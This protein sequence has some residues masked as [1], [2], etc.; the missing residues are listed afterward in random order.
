MEVPPRLTEPLVLC[1]FISGLFFQCCGFVGRHDFGGVILFI[2]IIK[3]LT[4]QFLHLN[5]FFL[6]LFVSSCD[7]IGSKSIPSLVNG[8]G[9]GVCLCALEL[10]RDLTQGLFFGSNWRLTT[11][12]KVRTFKSRKVCIHSPQCCPIQSETWQFALYT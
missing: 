4:E 6:C 9:I 1:N 10:S 7:L 2:I 5:D 12:S 3:R 8:I 11:I